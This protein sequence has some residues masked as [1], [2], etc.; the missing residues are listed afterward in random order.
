MNRYFGQSG[1]KIPNNNLLAGYQNFSNKNVPFNNNVM[2]MNNPAFIGSIRDPSFHQRIQNEK[3]ERIRRT[4]SINDLKMPVDKVTNYIICPIKI[5]KLTESDAI[6][7]YNDKGTQYGDN[8]AAK[9]LLN[10][11]YDSRTNA[12]YKTFLKA[13]GAVKEDV[14]QRKYGKQDDLIV[15]KV[16]LIDRDQVLLEAKFN[17]LEREIKKHNGELELIY[18]ASEKTKHL[19][20]FEYTN[21]SKYRVKYDPSN[22]DDLKKIY[23]KEQ[24]KIEKVGKRI[25]D[26]IESLLDRDDLSKEDL[27]ELQSL[28]KSK[29]EEDPLE[30]LEQELM[31]K[32]RSELNDEEYNAVLADINGEK[33]T[34]PKKSRRIKV[35]TVKIDESKSEE[36]EG[37]ENKV[38]T[39]KNI[40]RR[41]TVKK[42]E[43]N[44]DDDKYKVDDEL[45]EKYKKQ[46][47]KD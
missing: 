25:D 42:L 46:K 34:S 9:N 31:D 45:I 11:W 13:S 2:L 20:K 39:S 3:Q 17:E 27:E 38:K 12:P 15:Q 7:L 22:F 47:N 21:K 4:K 26:I 28:T 1:N 24:K 43:T 6:R 40:K 5:E 14:Y 8:A 35:T 23:K 10:S 33:T 44:S 16:S 29:K 30:I 37:N 32:L 36:I 41:I 19:E 18:S